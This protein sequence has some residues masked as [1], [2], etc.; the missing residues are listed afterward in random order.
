MGYA[1]FAKP[2][3]T[4]G[5]GKRSPRRLG[6]DAGAFASIIGCAA[7]PARAMKLPRSAAHR[8][9]RSQALRLAGA[10][11]TAA[12]A[13]IFLIIG[14]IVALMRRLAAQMPMPPAHLVHHPGIA[15]AA[16]ERHARGPPAA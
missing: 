16:P 11:M 14:V 7:G 3:A 4:T 10:V 8:N 5:L 12:V 1:G 15:A 2:G 9:K 13:I 6:N